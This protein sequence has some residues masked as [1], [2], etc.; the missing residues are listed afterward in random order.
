MEYCLD[1]AD[2]ITQLN[3]TKYGLQAGIFTRDIHLIHRV[4]IQIEVSALIV[5]DYPTLRIDSMPYGGAKSSGFGHEGMKDAIEQVSEN[6]LVVT[7]N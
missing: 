6:R 3:N 4:I 2:A 7:P 5:N 1:E